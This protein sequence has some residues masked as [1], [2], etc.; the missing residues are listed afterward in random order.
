MMANGGKPQNGRSGERALA[1]L[2]SQFVGQRLRV[3]L[4]GYLASGMMN[5]ECTYSGCLTV[6]YAPHMR[7]HSHWGS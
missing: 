2:Y 3:V 6:G 1:A 7:F 5:P 4:S